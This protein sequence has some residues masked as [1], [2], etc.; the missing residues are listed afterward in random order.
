M[1]WAGPLLAAAGIA[2][3]A[4]LAVLHPP[5]RSPLTQ[6]LL[7]AMLAP[8]GVLPLIGLGAA[9]A[10]ARSRPALA[11]AVALI[12]ATVAGLAFDSALL[13]TLSTI[14]SAGADQLFYAR[15]V[16]YVVVGVTLVAGPAMRNVLIAPAAALVGIA[17]ALQV[18]LSVPLF[19]STATIAAGT[20]VGL[21]IVAWVAITVRAFRQAWFTIALRIAGSWLVAIGLLY[22]GAS[23]ITARSGAKPPVPPPAPDTL[24]IPDFDTLLP[25]LGGD[26]KPPAPVN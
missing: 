23:V 13:A 6:W 8:A 20:V 9:L 15:P 10:E 1:R 11:G 17:L 7:L 5:A 19:H 4:L 16:A 14:P 25:D 2:I 24:T 21:W 3:L 12:A 18:D 26:K 22:G